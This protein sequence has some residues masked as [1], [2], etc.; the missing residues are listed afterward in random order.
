LHKVNTHQRIFLGPHGG[1]SIFY[2]DLV[3]IILSEIQLK[4]SQG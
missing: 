2:T 3:Y 1:F 4:I